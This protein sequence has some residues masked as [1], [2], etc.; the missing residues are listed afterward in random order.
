MDFKEVSEATVKD[1]ILLIFKVEKSIKDDFFL[2]LE[3][4][5]CGIFITISK[6]KEIIQEIINDGFLSYNNIKDF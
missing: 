5:R 3:L 1:T 4:R 2:N 6:Q